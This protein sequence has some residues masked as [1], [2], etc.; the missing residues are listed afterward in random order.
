MPSRTVELKP[1]TEDML[2]KVAQNL[3]INMIPLPPKLIYSSTCR[4]M[5][6]TYNKGL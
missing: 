4:G 3:M 6:A 5:V 1:E 2:K